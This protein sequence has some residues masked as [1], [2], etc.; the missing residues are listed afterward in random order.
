MCGNFF[1]YLIYADYLGCVEILLSKG[2]GKSLHSFKLSRSFKMVQLL[3]KY[4]VGK[5]EECTLHHFMCQ[6][7]MNDDERAMILKSLIDYGKDV[8]EYDEVLEKTPSEMD[9]TEEN[10]ILILIKAGANIKNALVVYL[11]Y[12]YPTDDMEEYELDKI[13]FLLQYGAD[14]S[15]ISYKND[16]TTRKFMLRMEMDDSLIYENNKTCREYLMTFPWG[17]QCYEKAKCNQEIQKIE[18]VEELLQY[19]VESKNNSEG[20]MS[21]CYEN[22]LDFE[23]IVGEHIVPMLFECNR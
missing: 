5:N 4:G 21:L 15:L 13:V 2:L 6:F 1:E 8:N 14:D 12:I 22:V 11:E 7:E 23:K 20:F 18:Q 10:D 9:T 3:I 19:F 16:K 17:K